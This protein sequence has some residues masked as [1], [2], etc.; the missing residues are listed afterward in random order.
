MS[1]PA[2]KKIV[3]VYNAE[4]GGAFSAL[5]D[6]LHKVFRRN[7]YPCNLC[8]ITFGTFRMKKGWKNFVNNLDAPVEFLKKDKFKFEFLH[9][10]EFNEIRWFH[11]DHIP[12]Q[13]SDPHMKRFISKLS[14]TNVCV[15]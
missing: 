3:F 12:Y 2:E 5:K 6:S 10:D 7:N 13:K 9:K 11:Y 4:S 15:P 14:L 1:E 8:A